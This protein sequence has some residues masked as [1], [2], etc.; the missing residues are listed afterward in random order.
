MSTDDRTSTRL[1]DLARRVDS[2]E[3]L[4]LRTWCAVVAAL[5]IAGSLI[6][7]GYGT[8]RGEPFNPSVV[9][10]PWRMI[11]NAGGED[12][13]DGPELAVGV[14]AI[15]GF[16]GLLAV[17]LAM[18]GTLTAVAGRDAGDGAVRFARVLRVLALIG[19]AVVLIFTLLHMNSKLPDTSPGVGGLVLLAG[20]IGYSALLVPGVRSLWHTP[21]S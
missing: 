2:L 15:I 19:A 5:L 21:I 18:L 13:T 16:L 8:E 17:V 6:P 7:F 1:H 4:L 11:A 3:S 9:T 14:L 12:G 10:F 20:V